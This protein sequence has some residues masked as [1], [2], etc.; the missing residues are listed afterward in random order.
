MSFL[1]QKLTHNIPYILIKKLTIRKEQ[2]SLLA[3]HDSPIIYKK[4][5]RAS[6]F[7]SKGSL[8]LEAALVVPIFFFAML[9]MVYLLEIMSIQ[10]TMRNAMYSVG[11]EI[12]Q[13]AYSSPMIS[14]YGIEQHIIKN[15]GAD[16]LNN[17]IVAGGVSGINCS[18]STSDWNTAV[19]DLSVQYQLVIPILVFRIPAISCE[20]SLRVKGWTGYVAGM[21]GDTQDEVVYVTDYGLVYHENM[22]CTYL[23][24][25]IQEVSWAEIDHLRNA[26]GEKY[27]PCETCGSM[28]IAAGRVYITDY[29]NRYHVSLDCNKVKRNIYAVPLDEVYGLG[30]CSKCVK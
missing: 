29:G 6:A 11:K 7:T 25:S 3:I 20:E 16:N 22:H 2:D 13:Q 28:S 26:S 19:I 30:G 8:T 5:E 18:Q 27:Y 12:A 4:E 23:E 15:I 9:C 21:Y 1:N 17:S 14:T 24:L 10:T